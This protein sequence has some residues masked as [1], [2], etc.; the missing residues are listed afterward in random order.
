MQRYRHAK[1]IS[2]VEHVM[3]EEVLRR[4]GLLRQVKSGKLK[5]FGHTMRHGSLEKVIM[6]GIMPRK[7]WQ[8]SQ[9]KQWMDDIVQRGERSLVKMVR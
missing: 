3:N 8:G 1:R 9:K 2:Y 4:V 7:R 6:L 5:Y